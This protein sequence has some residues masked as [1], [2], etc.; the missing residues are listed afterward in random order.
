MTTVGYIFDFDG[1][2]VHTMESHFECYG[3]ALA[4]FGVPI[5]R[6][7]FFRHAGMTGREQIKYFADRASVE[8]DV[9]AVYARKRELW[10]IAPPRVAVIDSNLCLL[11]VLREAGIPVA[12]A[13]GSTP[14]TIG[15]IMQSLGI[16]V[17]AVV[18]ADDV[19]RGKPFPDLFIQASEKLGVDPARCVVIEDSDVGIEAARA[20]GMQ[21]MRY[22]ENTQAGLP[23]AAVGAD[24]EPNPDMCAA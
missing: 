22:F 5:D 14:P 3:R 16:E 11:R 21:A 9:E 13:T 4:E 1:V 6:D 24:A 15:P 18:T 19:S 20:A 7:L 12:I 17:D 8:V 10:E 23:D 2:L